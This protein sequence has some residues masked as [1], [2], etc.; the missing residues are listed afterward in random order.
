[1][2]QERGIDLVGGWPLA[3]VRLAIHGL[4]QPLKQSRLQLDRENPYCDGLSSCGL[5]S[6]DEAGQPGARS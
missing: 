1:M 3:G 6:C 4:T 5:T 2:A